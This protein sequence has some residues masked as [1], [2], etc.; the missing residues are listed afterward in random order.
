ME[1]VLALLEKWGDVPRGSIRPEHYLLD[2]LKVDGDDYAM[3]LVPEIK[4]NFGINPKREEWER[5]VT[6][7]ELFDLVERHLARKG[8]PGGQA[9]A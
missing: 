9:S 5:V 1:L 8:S 3:S 6:V 4:K 2:D 7:Q